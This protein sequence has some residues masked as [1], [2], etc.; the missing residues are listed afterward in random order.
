[1]LRFSGLRRLWVSGIGTGVR[2][3]FVQTTMERAKGVPGAPDHANELDDD[4]AYE[5]ES[6]ASGEASR[7]PQSSKTYPGHETRQPCSYGS[8]HSTQTP[9]RT[10]VVSDRPAG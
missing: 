9:C 1:M 2:P 7:D 4:D 10:P 3:A 5:D 8:T 6:V